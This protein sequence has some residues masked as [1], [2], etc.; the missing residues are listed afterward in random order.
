MNY[1][2]I[3]RKMI[4]RAKKEQRIKSK[5]RYYEKHHII[6]DF[7]FKN[8]KRPGPRGHLEGNPD[9]PNN[10]VFLTP[11]EHLL[12]HM[13]LYRILK[14]THYEHSAG[15]AMA[16][17]FSK[18]IDR[19]P[20]QKNSNMSNNKKYEWCRAIGRESI[21]KARKGKIPAK[22]AITGFSVGSVSVDHPKVLI[23]EWVHITKGR[24]ISQKERLNRK[25]QVGSNNINYKEMTENRKRRLFNLVPK[26]IIEN[27]LQ[28]RL[29]E[30]FLKEEFSEFK[31][32]SIVWVKNNFYTY[33]NFL[34]ECNDYLNTNYEYDPYFRSITH[35]ANSRKMNVTK[36]WYTDGTKNLCIRDG[37]S[38]P[39]NFKR[40]RNKC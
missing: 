6:P 29:L 35:R 24:I 21:S 4:I 25:S 19:H 38:I 13:M 8:R 23:G 40:G 9:N 18:V 27:H 17:F 11:R 32:I 7:M 10:L 28:I 36:K 5:D 39:S 37:E 31:K 33:Q 34:K 2:N 26:A 20:R 22:D 30:D 15:S 3:Y 12:S 14:H 1:K 16:F